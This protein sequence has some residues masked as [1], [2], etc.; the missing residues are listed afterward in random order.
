MVTQIQT[1]TSISRNADKSSLCVGSSVSSVWSRLLL[2]IYSVQ[3]SSSFACYQPTYWP[4]MCCQSVLPPPHP[5][6]LLPGL[7]VRGITTDH[8]LYQGSYSAV[9]SVLA[10][11][12]CWYVSYSSGRISFFLKPPRQLRQKTHSLKVQPLCLILLKYNLSL[13]CKQLIV[14]FDLLSTSKPVAI[15]IRGMV[16][17][18]KNPTSL[19]L[20]RFCQLK[21][22]S[23]ILS[24][25]SPF[26][27]K[28]PS[29]F[30]FFLT[31][32]SYVRA[33]KQINK[34]KVTPLR[35]SG[36]TA[37][38]LQH[39]YLVNTWHQW[40]TY[41]ILGLIRKYRGRRQEVGE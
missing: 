40:N 4:Q 11:L 1:P 22:R 2:V 34:Q 36:I 33:R 29:P 35:K 30:F 28:L 38:K 39:N 16:C 6:P 10:W 26:H 5:Q 23:Q 20:F 31:R 14:W 19:L 13:T 41:C 21:K 3:Q 15:L 17:I 8:P 32:A 27:E 24:V 7:H 12:L 18:K 37:R 25:G 9:A